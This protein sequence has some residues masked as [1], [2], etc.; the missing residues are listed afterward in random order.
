MLYP[1]ILVIVCLL[2]GLSK[3]GLGAALAVLAVPLLSQVMPVSAAQGVALPLLIVADWFALWAY[4]GTWNMHYIWRT[5]PFATIGIVVGTALLTGLPN[6]TLKH[7]VALFTLFFVLYRLFGDRLM[8]AE[9][10]PRTWHAYF[11]GA[12]SGLGSALAN[13]GG[14]PFTAYMLLQKLEPLPFVGTITLFFAIV[15]AL[16]L[17]G[18]M[19]AGI[20]DFSRLLS[21]IWVLPVLPIGVWIGRYVIK[22]INQ[23]VFERFMLVMLVLTALIL[24]FG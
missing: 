4:R 10:Q 19:I 1:I 11:A 20:F 13:V 16:K 5:I 18:L 9:Y 3:G 21:M 12:I 6:Q 8:T 14:P 23:R 17:P 15:N 22:R 7:I 2:I 24:L